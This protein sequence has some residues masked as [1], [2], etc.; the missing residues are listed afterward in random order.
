M[1]EKVLPPHALE[2]L[3]ALEKRRSAALR[4]WVLAGGA[5]L[6]L[7]LGH[8]AAGAFDFFRTNAV[9]MAALLMALG[10]AGACEVLNHD[11]RTLNVLVGGTKLAFFRVSFGVVHPPTPYRFFAV[12]DLMDLALMKL[13]AIAD[14]GSRKDFVDLWCILQ[15]GLSL[16]ECIDLLPRKYGAGHVNTYHVL[17]S[18]AYFDDAEKEPMPEL[19]RA[20]DWEKCKAYFAKEARAIVLPV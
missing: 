14:R 12:A 7:R 10:R 16:R 4:G 13:V 15:E 20:L 17:K 9:D 5:A 1:H 19:L 6:A 3:T 11:A 8:R 18:L 2:L